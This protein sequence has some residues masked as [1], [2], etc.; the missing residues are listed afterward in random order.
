MDKFFERYNL[1]RINQK[2]IEKRNR[3]ITSTEIETG[4]LKSP[5]NKSPEQDGFTGKSYQIFRE[6]LTLSFQNYS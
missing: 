5:T 6:E 4:I 2:E 1:P 3:T